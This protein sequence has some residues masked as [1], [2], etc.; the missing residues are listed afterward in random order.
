MAQSKSGHVLHANSA[1]ILRTKLTL[2]NV[3]SDSPGAKENHVAGGFAKLLR[4]DEARSDFSK[5]HF[6][7]FGIPLTPGFSS[8]LLVQ[9]ILSII[10]SDYHCIDVSNLILLKYAL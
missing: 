2:H 9:Y 1:L 5:K 8:P 7:H 6:R 3:P 4:K 10:A